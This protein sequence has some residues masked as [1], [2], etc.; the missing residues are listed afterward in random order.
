MR[1]AL[2]VRVIGIVQGV[3]F[4]PFIYRLAHEYNI[5]GWVLNAADG[6]TIHAEGESADLDAFV[7]DIS[8]AAP[9]A[10]QV[11]RIQMHEIPLENFTDFQIH[12]SEDTNVEKTTLVS[13]D[14]AT[15]ADCERELF[16]P[17]DRRYH[18]P[19]IN[20]TNCGPRFTITRDLPYDRANTSMRDFPMCECCAA[21]YADPL[22]RRFHAQ[23]DA[24]FEC[25][26]H[27]AWWTSSGASPELFDSS[28]RDH[29]SFD[30]ALWGSNREISD[31]IIDACARVIDAGGIMAIKGL[32]GFHL[33]CDANNE[34]ALA[35]L[36]ERKH[37]GNKPFA[38]MVKS[39][40]VARDFCEIS[41]EEEKV[42]TSPARPIVLLR[43]RSDVSFAQGLADGLHELGVMLP[44]TPLQH[45]LLAACQ[46]PLL[47]MTSGNIHDEPIQI[48]DAQAARALD[49]IADAFVGH[50]RPILERYDDSVVRVLF[51]GNDETMVQVLRRARGLA[52]KPLAFFEESDAKEDTSDQQ[53]ESGQDASSSTSSDH[54]VIFAT[55]PE[56]K[57]TFCMTRPGEAFVSQHIGDVENAPTND[58]WIET[59][60]LFEHLFRMTPTKVVC[61]SHPEY[62]TSKWA[63]AQD[64]PV[65]QVQHHHAHIA[66]VLGEHNIKDAVLGLALDGTGYGVDGTIWGGEAL[67]ANTT[68][69][70]RFANF[71][72]FPLPSG[73]GA[74]KH[75][76]RAAYGVLWAFDLLDHPG[77]ARAL[78]ELGEEAKLCEQM[79]DRGINCPL[80]SSAGR[81][82]DAASALV[83]LCT[84]ATYEGEGA[85]LFE[86]V[87]DTTE[88]AGEPIASSGRAYRVEIVKN[89]ATETSSA[90]DTSVVLLDAAPLFEALLD[91][92]AA[93]VSPGRIAR[94]FHDGMVAALVEIAHAAWAL[95]DL[96]TVA[97]S[98]GVFQNRYLTEQVVPALS[99]EG[100]TVA[101]NRDLPPNDGCISYGQAVVEWHVLHDKSSA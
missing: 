76:L 2:S 56:Q 4:R 15:C 87:I 101:L 31:S 49:Q 19:F 90:Q 24:C 59:K 16:D 99:Q 80:T 61:D 14:L 83:G 17:Q 44:A 92:C 57:V 22:D 37:R 52:P 71:A 68:S 33:A 74:I 27:L 64:L 79:I 65:V 47:V 81:L 29:N 40:E 23:P 10:A 75:T 89:T 7:L 42:L 25:G 43:K 63:H 51:L 100:F 95:Y 41:P 77:A 91:D 54:E 73:Q 85:C 55:G 50:N 98:G 11:E 96:K 8:E 72:Y 66:S 60:A 53:D 38:C 28:M 46:S 1:E 62:L 86:A 21:E 6:V 93:G 26:P 58:S 69:F 82:F 48:D 78:Q 13:P 94:R 45:L 32:G 70:E 35:L 30:Q 18:Y 88:E 34:C 20:C 3:G 9:A 12:F 39:L 67:L 5:F 36:R 97:L 84:Q